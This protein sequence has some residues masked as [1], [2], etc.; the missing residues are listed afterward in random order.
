[1][2]RRISI[3]I[4]IS[5]GSPGVVVAQPLHSTFCS[6]RRGVV[7]VVVV[8]VIVNVL[9][10]LIWFNFTHVISVSGGTWGLNLAQIEIPPVSLVV[11]ALVLHSNKNHYPHT[12]VPNKS[13][14]LDPSINSNHHHEPCAGL[15]I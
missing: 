10:W 14:S 8:I 7:V 12:L 11:L 3:R 2:C 1:M 6:S 5:K 4:W 9:W 13:S 15:R